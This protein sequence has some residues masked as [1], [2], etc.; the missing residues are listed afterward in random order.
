MND[1]WVTMFKFSVVLILL[2]GLI[3]GFMSMQTASN[4]V[5]QRL[6]DEHQVRYTLMDYRKYN[7]YDNKIVH[8]ADVVSLI[9][10]EQGGSVGI[11]VENLTNTGGY[12]TAVN[13]RQWYF[14]RNA[15]NVL[16]VHTTP[17]AGATP[18]NPVSISGLQNLILLDSEF[19]ASLEY[20]A[21]ENVGIIVFRRRP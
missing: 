16:V 17:G 2:A 20:T 4:R 10:A 9:L 7:A 14:T 12:T 8:G 19:N 3:T 1:S 18:L 5:F 21:N 15:A 13:A 11:R 6:E